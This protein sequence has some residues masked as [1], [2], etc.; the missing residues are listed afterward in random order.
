MA[1]EINFAMLDMLGFQFNCKKQIK[2][3]SGLMKQNYKDRVE[4]TTERTSKKYV[5]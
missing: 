4:V 5:G 1:A 2:M 3:S